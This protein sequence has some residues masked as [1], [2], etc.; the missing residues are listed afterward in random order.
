MTF[1][2]LFKVTIIQRQITWKWYNVQLYLQWPTDRKSYMIY[3][4]ARFSMTLNDA[5]HLFQGHAVLW[6]WISQ[7]RYNIQTQFQWNTNRDLHTPYSTVSFR[8]T[9]S[10]FFWVTSQN[11]QWHEASRGL[12]DS[13]ASCSFSSPLRNRGFLEI[14]LTFLT[15]STADLIPCLAKWL[16]PTR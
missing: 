14:L 3:Q 4:T 5:Y 8:M 9:L 15:Q 2:D 12:C 7:K 16:T 10:D 1:S 13:W 6:S 11:I